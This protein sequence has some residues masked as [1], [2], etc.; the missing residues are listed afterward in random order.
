MQEYFKWL[1]TAIKKY[2]KM[3]IV[4]LILTWN[5]FSF[6]IAGAVDDESDFVTFQPIIVVTAILSILAVTVVLIIYFR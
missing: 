5:S 6:S 2:F 1:V 3:L 4:N